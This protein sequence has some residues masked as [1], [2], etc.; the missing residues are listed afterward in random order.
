VEAISNSEAWSY[1]V[2]DSTFKDSD[3]LLGAGRKATVKVISNGDSYS[4]AVSDSAV[5]GAERLLS[6]SNGVEVISNGDAYSHTVFDSRLKNT[7]RLL[8]AGGGVEVVS[9][10]ESWSYPVFVKSWQIIQVDGKRC[11]HFQLSVGHFVRALAGPRDDCTCTG[12]GRCTGQ[13]A[14]PSCIM[15]GM[16]L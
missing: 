15:Q 4:H 9:N 10:G 16:L 8:G 12:I 11:Q 14:E 5:R 3:K 6:I 2:F 13:L 7:E 1:P